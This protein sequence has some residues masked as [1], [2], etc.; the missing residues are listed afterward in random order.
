MVA[1][2]SARRQAYVTGE[3]Q[4]KNVCRSREGMPVGEGATT[5]MWHC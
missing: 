3:R 4:M 1:V 2:E 5:A